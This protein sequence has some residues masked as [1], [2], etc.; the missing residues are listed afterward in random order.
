MFA[1]KKIAMVSCD[2]VSTFVVVDV[3]FIPSTSVC[4]VCLPEIFNTKYSP[5]NSRVDV[6]ENGNVLR[7][8]RKSASC[9]PCVLLLMLVRTTRRRTPLFDRAEACLKCS[10]R[11]H[12]R[13]R[14]IKPDTLEQ[15]GLRRQ[16]IGYK[17][18]LFFCVRW[19]VV[20]TFESIGNVHRLWYHTKES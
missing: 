8:A 11:E 15:P 10:T 18:E 4:V 6:I 17:I 3:I 12:A 9:P 1:L 2:N 14:A 20:G 7:H 19:G 16:M 5:V 13:P